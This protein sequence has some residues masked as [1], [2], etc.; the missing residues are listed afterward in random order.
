MTTRIDTAAIRR[1]YP[2][3]GV[4]ERYGVALRHCGAHLVGRCPFHDDH[5]PS[6]VLYIDQPLDEHF[7][8]FG[9]GAHGDVIR[10]VELIERLPFRD[11]VAVL[12]GLQPDRASHRTDAGHEPTRRPQVVLDPAHRACLAVATALYHQQLL[13]DRAALAYCAQRGLD[14]ATIVRCQLGSATGANLAGALRRAGLDLAPAVRAGLLTATGRERLAG[15]LIVPELRAG[16]PR[17][18]IGRALDTRTTPRYLGLPGRKPLLGWAEAQDQPAV[19]LTEGVIDRLVLS[20]WGLPAL[21]LAGTH[22]APAALA[23]LARFPRLY[24]VL[25]NDTAG[26]AATATLQAALGGRARP[27]ALP[28]GCKDVAELAEHPGGRAVFVRALARASGD[29]TALAA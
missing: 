8:C 19:C 29:P 1:G 13:R 16:W 7:H 10:F 20:G 2:L 14:R 4:V 21:A 22:A 6:L 24:L 9:C 26:R 23:A 27:M 5:E 28:A 25:D 3:S 18:L 11:A 12:T 15:R 17:W